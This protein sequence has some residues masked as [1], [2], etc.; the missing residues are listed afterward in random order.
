MLDLIGDG[1]SGLVKDAVLP[2]VGNV[3]ERIAER[4]SV[5]SWRPL[6][7]LATG[8]RASRALARQPVGAIRIG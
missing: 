1:A 2:V 6:R 8:S 4:V 5:E 7:E 3:L